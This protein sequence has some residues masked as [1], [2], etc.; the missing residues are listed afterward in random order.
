VQRLSS[1]ASALFAL[2]SVTSGIHHVWRH[3]RKVDAEHDDAVSVDVHSCFCCELIPVVKQHG[4]VNHMRV[5]GSVMDLR[6]TACFLS[7]PIATLMW[8]VLTFMITLVSY[9]FQCSGEVGQVFLAVVIT[10]VT[11]CIAGAFIC[12]WYETIDTKPKEE[13]A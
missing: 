8:S 7:L 2:T 1:L 11:S 6:L 12:F 4:Y 5:V 13:I 9:C 3:K 10:I